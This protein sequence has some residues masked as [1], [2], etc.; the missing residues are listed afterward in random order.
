[1]INININIAIFP[2]MQYTLKFEC[3]LRPLIECKLH[4]IAYFECRL[5]Q[6]CTLKADSDS[7][8]GMWW[9]VIA[10]LE[11]GGLWQLTCNVVNCDSLLGMWWTVTAYLEWRLWQ[12]TWN[13]DYDSIFECRLWIRNVTTYSYFECRLLTWHRTVK[14]CIACFK[15]TVDCDIIDNFNLDSDSLL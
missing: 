1:M 7:L 13:V 2:F 9:T 12:L 3:R 14:Y 5:R 6:H 11:C 15:Y 10:Y 8:L 4:V